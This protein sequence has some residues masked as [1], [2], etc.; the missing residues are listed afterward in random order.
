M[1]TKGFVSGTITGVAANG[2]LLQIYPPDCPAGIAVAT[3]TPAQMIREPI[4][5]ELVGFQVQTNGSDG[6]VFELW[7]VAGDDGGADV[8]TAAV[9]TNAEL[10]VAQNKGKASLLWRQNLLGTG[11]TPP[12]PSYFRFMRGLAA[13]WVSSGNCS[14]SGNISGGYRLR[15]GSV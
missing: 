13:R 8:S 1:S 7:D 4:E 14:M 10:V 2:N 12:C 5:G 15:H 11:V 9:I 6:G 3:A